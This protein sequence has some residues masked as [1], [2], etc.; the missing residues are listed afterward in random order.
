MFLL[1]LH[2]GVIGLMWM[3]WGH[4]EVVVCI[5]VREQREISMYYVMGW[6]A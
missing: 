6:L 4:M 2:V 3:V 1:V 5:L